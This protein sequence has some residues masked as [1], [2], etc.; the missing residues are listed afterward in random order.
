MYDVE[1]R[2]IALSRNLIVHKGFLVDATV[3]DKN[4]LYMLFARFHTL[5]LY[6][7]PYRTRF[8]CRGHFCVCVFTPDIYS[9]IGTV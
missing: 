1:G 7:L 2:L 8:V 4:K 6:A 5:L 9:S 3:R